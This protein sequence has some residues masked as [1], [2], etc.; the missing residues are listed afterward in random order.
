MKKILCL[1][2]ALVL[3]AGAVSVEAFALFG[4][5]V[6]VIASD[7]SVIKTGL[8]GK[9]LKFSDSDFKSAFA[10]TD[11]DSISGGYEHSIF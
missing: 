3:I 8:F 2:L 4:S 7:V 5:G 6:E 11:F 10:I 1:T 9:K